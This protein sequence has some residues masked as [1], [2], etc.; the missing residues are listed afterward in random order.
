M[1]T[2][3]NIISAARTA[4]DTPFVHQGRTV[5]KALDCAG[6]LI[7]IGQV[8]K[9][10]PIDRTNY[11]RRPSGG[12]LQIQ[13]DMQ[14]SIEKVTGTLL[15]GDILLMRFSGEPQH[16]A[17]YTDPNIIHAYEAAGRVV[18]HILDTSWKSRIVAIYRF[19]EL[20]YE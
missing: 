5:G 3:N 20:N 17:I 9:L 11:P 1:I 6:L 16:L 4:I 14:K 13:L 10:D 2:P 15:P 7:Y 18:E 8:L 19:K 12:Q